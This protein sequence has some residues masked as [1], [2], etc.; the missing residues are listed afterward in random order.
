MSDS[1]NGPYPGPRAFLDTEAALFRGRADEINDLYHLVGAYRAV[2]LYAQSGAGKTSLINAGLIPRLGQSMQVVRMRVGGSLPPGLALKPIRNIYAFNALSSLRRDEHDES[3]PPGA[4]LEQ[5]RLDTGSRALI[6]FDQ[7]EELFTSYPQRWQDREP[8]LREVAE[9]LSG[10]SGFQ[11]LFVMRHDKLAEL[12]AYSA[13]LPEGLRIRYQIER[14]GKDSAIEAIVE[15]AAERGCDFDLDAAAKLVSDLRKSRVETAGGVE[16]IQGEFVEPLH[17]QVVCAQLWSSLPP[18]TKRIQSTHTR[19]H[20]DVNRALA[21]YYEE[22]VKLAVERGKVSEERLRR[23][24]ETKLITPSGTRGIVYQ[25]RKYTEGVSNE[26]VRLLE[27]RHMIRDEPRAGAHWYELTHDRFIEPIR[28]SNRDWERRQ[29]LAGTA[30]VWFGG[31]VVGAVFLGLAGL[32]TYLLAAFW[33]AAGSSDVFLFGR[34]FSAAFEIRLLCTVAVAGAMG[35]YVQAATSF[36]NYI[37]N[38]AFSRSWTW[39]YILRTP[40]GI[41]MA[42]LV[43]FVVRA[44]LLPEA[45]PA[46]LNVYGIAALSALAGLFSRQVVDKLREV[47][48]DLFVTG[49]DGRAD[50]LRAGR[51]VVLEVD[52]SETVAGEQDVRVIVRGMHFLEGSTLMV[53]AGARHTVFVNSFEIHGYLTERDLANPG[54]LEVAVA[55]PPPSKVG[56]N[57]VRLVV[58][59]PAGDRAQGASA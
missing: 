21:A 51:P 36:A 58:A 19:T 42:L 43:Y 11:A 59:A 5:L 56:S 10:R 52:P 2:L 37:G 53:N 33:P 29:N 48:E 26:V 8:F 47:F 49:P 35:S 55:Y 54:I 41:S 39:W 28:N 4:S 57:V 30:F 7:F 20:G 18:G 23:W 22:S 27:D 40:I 32:L 6:V 46:S 31:P 38:R 25:D 34:R 17:L 14:L 9:W 12:E 16:E 1:A 50:K 44:G 15:P 13:I 45:A 3:P 24:F